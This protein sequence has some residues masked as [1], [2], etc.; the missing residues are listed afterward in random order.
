MMPISPIVKQIS[1]LEPFALF[2]NLYQEPSAILLEST[3]R[4][5]QF[6]RYSFIAMDPFSLITSKNGL[7]T[8]NNATFSGDPFVLLQT[9]LKQYSTTTLPNL[10]PFQGGAAGF[11]SYDLCHH[12]EKLP[13]ANNDLMAF[14]DLAIGFYDVVIAF[15]HIEKKAWI[16]SN[17]FP[18]QVPHHREKRAKER[19]LEIE[20]KIITSAKQVLFLQNK[21]SVETLLASFT[22]EQYMA[23]VKRVIDFIHAGDIFQANVTQ[24]FSADLPNDFSPLLLYHQL[25]QVNPAPFA[26]FL[27]FSDTMLL[28]ASPER[29]LQ[30]QSGWIEARPIKGTRPRDDNVEKDQKLAEE[31]LTSE[32]E[33]AENTMIV[34]LLRNDLSRVCVDHSVQ[35]TQLC[36]L[37]SFATVHHLVSVIIGQLKPEKDAIDLLRATFPGG[38]ITG[39]PKLRAMEIIAELEPT[40]RG[41]YCGC[42]GYIGFD[43]T[44][45]TAITI[46]TYTIKNKKITFQTGGGIV[47]DSDPLM[48]YQEMQ[49]KAQALQHALIDR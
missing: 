36:G 12:L 1:Y 34:D 29:F 7:I 6:G 15:D 46:R 4:S 49:I 21:T 44:I 38:S 10:P 26:A 47:A 48:E 3:K 14:P 28:S 25:Q 5:N 17:G 32:K 11:F 42:F 22:K 16:F 20:Q 43:G 31:L 24:C 13:R 9:Q 37:E 8:H 19:L 18:E 45:D 27:N 2:A 40:A 41:P 33:R 39:A 35:V 30:L 23:M